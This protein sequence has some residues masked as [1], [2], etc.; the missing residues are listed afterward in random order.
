VNTTLPPG[1]AP[2]TGKQLAILD[3]AERLFGSHGYDGTSVRDIAHEAGVN[4]AMI[5]YYF[6]SKEGLLEALFAARISAGRLVLEHLLNNA[7]MD[8]IAKIEALVDRIVDRMVDHH[9]FY[10]IMLRAQL[11]EDNE[12]V[13]RMIGDM[14]L[15]NLE[16]VTKLIAEGQR[17]KVFVKNVDPAMMMTTLIGTIYQAAIGSRYFKASLQAE[18]LP[19]ADYADMLRKKLKTHLKNVLKATLTHDGK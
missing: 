16:L 14:K 15:T 3:A 17:K 2:Y 5:S 1:E 18:S 11:N 13:S 19:E 12:P 7:S 6:R 10:R 4:V 9:A 8:P